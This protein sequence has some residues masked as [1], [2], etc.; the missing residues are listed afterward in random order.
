MRVSFDLLLSIANLDLMLSLAL[1]SVSISSP[2]HGACFLCACSSCIQSHVLGIL[3]NNR[4][5]LKLKIAEK[6]FFRTVTIEFLRF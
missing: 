3:L 1:L 2:L 5:D 6:M 4:P